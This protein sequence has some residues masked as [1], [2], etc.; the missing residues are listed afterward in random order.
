[1]LRCRMMSQKNMGT[2]QPHEDYFRLFLAHS[3]R[4]VHNLP[5]EISVTLE[6][7]SR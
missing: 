6:R 1:M 4:D 5:I 7:R 3:M 2:M